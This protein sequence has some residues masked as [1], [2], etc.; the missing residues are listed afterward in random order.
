MKEIQIRGLAFGSYVRLFAVSGLCAGVF[1][2]ILSFFFALGVPESVIQVGGV[3]ASGLP[4]ALLGLFGTPIAG[5]LGFGLTAYITYFP[6]KLAIQIFVKMT[7]TA[8][9]DQ[10][11]EDVD[12]R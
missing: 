2:G 11:E 5:M 7:F 12:H 1:F 3:S 10:P 9:V 4:G 6:L 8:L